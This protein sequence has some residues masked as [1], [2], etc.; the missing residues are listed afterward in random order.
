MPATMT[1]QINGIDTQALRATMEAVRLDPASGKARFSAITSWRGGTRSE[2]R[3][4]KWSLGGKEL[5]KDFT[6][7]M[8]EP[9]ELLGR[10]TAAN[11]QE[12]LQASVNA[13]IMATWVAACAMHDIEL[14]ELVIESRGELDLRGFLG[15]DK[16][17]KPGYD[18]VQYTVRVKGNGTPEQYQAVH[19][20]VQATSPNFYNMANAVRM[21]AKVVIE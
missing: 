14:Q 21:N 17:V 8:D 7:A 11:P 10:N 9:P 1:R 12:Y 15:L 4:E 19:R 16:A 3:V 5:P 2:T 20:W 6:I 18:E 13:C